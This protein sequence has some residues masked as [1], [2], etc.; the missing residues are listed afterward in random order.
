MSTLHQLQP[1]ALWQHFAAICDIPHPSFHEEQI[2]EHL[3]GF[4]RQHNLEYQTDEAGN[5]IMRKPA[6]PGLEKKAGIIFQNHMDMVPQKNHGTEHDFPTAPIK[7][8]IDGDWV[9]AEGTT[10]GAD[11]GI[12][13]AAALA[14]L[15]AD[16]L[17]HGPIEAL[18]TSTEEAGMVGAQ[19]LK[20][21]V[22]NGKILLNLDTEDEGEL[23]TG[24]A[25]GVRIQING[26]YQPESGDASLKFMHLNLSGLKGGHSGCDIHLGRGNAIKLLVRALRQLENHQVR[27]ASFRSGS[28]PN[29]I[30][31]E[32]NATIALPGEQLESVAAI[33]D[34]LNSEFT[35]ELQQAE[36]NL[37]L[38]LIDADVSPLLPVSTQ[39]QWLAALAACP[40]GVLR[41]SDTVEGVVETSSNLGVLKIAEGKMQAQV[42]P[43]SLIDSCVTA[44]GDTVKG[45]FNLVDA[46]VQFIDPYPGW[47]PNADSNILSIMQGVYA[48]LYGQEPAVK[49]IHAGLEC[50]LLGSKYP[51]W[52][53]ISFGPTICFPHSPDEK[54]HIHSVQKFWNLLVATLKAIPESEIHR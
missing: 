48:N 18:F 19:G 14:V 28:V 24:C 46:E 4:A 25:G 17:E 41:M 15:A 51:E 31:R 10:L 52:D 9:T 35:N 7:A 54:V 30:P 3:I 2:L 33:V 5:I 39:N 20:P 50:G 43:R 22:L 49:V 42:M 1:T 34:Q 40:N 26:Q 6:T 37:K 32:A 12:G 45:L 13:M 8:Y 53:M 38:T 16:D 21:G 27:L 23:Y 11:N 29:A 36:P 47:Q 44:T